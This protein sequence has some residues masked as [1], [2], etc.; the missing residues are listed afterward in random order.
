M[1]LVFEGDFALAE[2]NAPA[3]ALSLAAGLDRVGLHP[4]PVRGHTFSGER[5][6]S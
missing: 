5:D 3:A 4:G 1:C 6:S 2:H